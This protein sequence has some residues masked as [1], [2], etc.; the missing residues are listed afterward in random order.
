[1]GIRTTRLQALVHA[2]TLRVAFYTDRIEIYYA[3]H[4]LRSIRLLAILRTLVLWLFAYIIELAYPGRFT[5]PDSDTPSWC[6]H[7]PNYKPDRL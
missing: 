2:Q 3:G 6:R 4:L 5:A 1:M 7:G